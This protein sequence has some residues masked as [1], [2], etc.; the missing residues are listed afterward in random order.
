MIERRSP[1]LWPSRLTGTIQLNACKRQRVAELLSTVPL[2]PGLLPWGEGTPLVSSWT[3]HRLA[4]QSSD[5]YQHFFQLNRSGVRRRSD[6]LAVTE[7]LTVCGS[8][9]GAV[10]RDMETGRMPVLRL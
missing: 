1:S 2:H 4:T 3:N 7:Q 6:F 10:V 5:R 9:H 8:I